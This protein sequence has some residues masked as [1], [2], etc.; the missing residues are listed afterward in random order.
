M[1][2]YQPQ[3]RGNKS[4]SRIGPTVSRKL[5]TAGWNISPSAR[6]YKNDGV[7]VSAQGDHVSVLV[8]LGL[9]AR[10]L[11]VGQSIADEVTTWDAAADIEVKQVDE[12]GS[13][14]VWFTY[15]R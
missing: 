7:F 13:V 1:A 15:G 9:D 2:G 8:D 3:N 11:R 6:K 10:N 5:R 12:T 14:F 4:A